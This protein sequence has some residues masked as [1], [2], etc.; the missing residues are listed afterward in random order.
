[1]A[2]ENREKSLSHFEKHRHREL[3]FVQNDMTKPKLVLVGNPNVG[4][5]LVFN[6]L[7]GIARLWMS[8]KSSVSLGA[9]AL[10]CLA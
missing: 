5:S 2:Q 8:M 4:K 6:A 9:L 1:M 3:S 10:A 7:S